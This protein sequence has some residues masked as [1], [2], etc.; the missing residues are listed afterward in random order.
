MVFLKVRLG[1]YQINYHIN[2]LGWGAEGSEGSGAGRGGI[3]MKC[4]PSWAEWCV[5]VFRVST[6]FEPPF[7]SCQKKGV[8]PLSM[9]IHHPIHLRLS[10]PHPS[11]ASLSQSTT[12]TAP[13]TLRNEEHF[14]FSEPFITTCRELG[15]KSVYMTDTGSKT[16]GFL[17][18]PTSS[19]KV[20]WDVNSLIAARLCTKSKQK[21]LAFSF[22]AFK[23]LYHLRS[24]LRKQVKM[25]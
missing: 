2:S 20:F 18:R 15:G 21:K 10:P 19:V 24:K 12:M 14:S 6:Y 9:F 11:A 13:T 4:N 3:G 25:C 23:T 8:F 5:C 22:L 7:I 16:L 17:G 1:H